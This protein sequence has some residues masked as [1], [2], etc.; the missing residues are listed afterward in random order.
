MQAYIGAVAQRMMAQ[1]M[2]L[3]EMWVGPAWTLIGQPIPDAAAALVTGDFVLGIAGVDE[4]SPEAVHGFPRQLDEFARSQRQLGAMGGA[5]SVACLVSER[6]NPASMQNLKNF[7]Q[8][9]SGVCPCVVDLGMRQ[10][11]I[12]SN[13]PFIGFAVFGSLRKK[14]ASFLPDPRQVLG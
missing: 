3:Q 2:R 7:S 12:A 13:T 8:F 9:G 11:H 4:I 10:L 6:V 5:M 14:A 1:R